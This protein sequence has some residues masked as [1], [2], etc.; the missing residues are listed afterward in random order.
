M[1]TGNEYKISLRRNANLNFMK[2]LLFESIDSATLL[3]LINF[4]VPRRLNCSN[5]PF[6]IPTRTANFMSNEPIYRL[7]RL[8]NSDTSLLE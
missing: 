7:M 5:I 3:S 4:K 6:H 1:I 2:S 8:L